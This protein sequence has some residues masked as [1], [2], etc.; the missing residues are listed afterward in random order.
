MEE[1]QSSFVPVLI[2]FLDVLVTQISAGRHPAVNL[3]LVVLE[4][5][6]GLQ[7]RLVLLAC[8]D[9]LVHGG[10]HGHRDRYRGR[11]VRINHG[12]VALHGGLEQRVLARAKRSDFAAPAVPHDTPAAGKPLAGGTELV[13]FG[14]DARDTRQGVWWWSLGLEEVTQFGLLIIGFWRVP[15]DIGGRALEEIG[16]E[17]AVGLLRVRSGED[18]GTLEGLVAVAKYIW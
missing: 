18:V 12:R 6:R 11:I 14:E 13:R 8:I 17:D 4:E 16:H 7:I 2:L 5:V 9:I 3:V 1:R 10:Q 15:G